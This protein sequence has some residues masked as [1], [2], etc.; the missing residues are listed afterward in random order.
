MTIHEFCRRVS[1]ACPD[2]RVSFTY[3]D[4]KWYVS[5]AGDYL[6]VDSEHPKNKEELEAYLDEVFAVFKQKVD[7]TGTKLILLA[8]D[9]QKI[10]LD[11]DL[12]V[13]ER[14]K[15][16]RYSPRK[17]RFW[18]VEPEKFDPPRETKSVSTQ[19]I[20]LRQNDPNIYVIEKEY[21]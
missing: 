20:H 21:R 8:K 13:W 15:Y 11:E 17:W 5:V 14:E 16:L 3:T 4:G 9:T 12:T 2:N 19:G 1:T 6:P 18:L 7:R 10:I